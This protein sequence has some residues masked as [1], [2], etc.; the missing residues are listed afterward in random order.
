MDN[1]WVEPNDTIGGLVRQAACIGV[2]DVT[3]LGI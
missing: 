1:E 3:A 2:E